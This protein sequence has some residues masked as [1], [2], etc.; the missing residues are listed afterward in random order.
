MKT[1]VITA[2]LDESLGR[3]IEFLKSS[4]KLSNTTSVLSHAIHLLYTTTKKKQ[5]KKSSLQLF[6]ESGLLGCFEGPSDLSTSYKD[7]IVTIQIPS[8]QPHV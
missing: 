4:L 5:S 3:E 2:R 8:V 7:E 6:E 1:K